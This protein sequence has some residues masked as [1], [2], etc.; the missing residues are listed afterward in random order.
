MKAA[1]E[2]YA[3]EA[4]TYFYEDF[5]GNKRIGF[6]DMQEKAREVLKAIEGE[7]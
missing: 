4:S 1:L 3:D 5:H 6:K 7:K 2:F